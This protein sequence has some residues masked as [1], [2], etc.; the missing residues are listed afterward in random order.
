[1]RERG[2]EI[3]LAQERERV[4][5]R[6]RSSGV[7]EDLGEKRVFPRV[8]GGDRRRS[9]TKPAGDSRDLDDEGAGARLFDVK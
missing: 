9:V 8:E 1:M 6:L 3:S 2:V 5:E 7:L 4:L